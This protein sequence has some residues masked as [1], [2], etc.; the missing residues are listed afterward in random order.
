KAKGNESALSDK[1]K[2]LGIKPPEKIVEKAAEGDDTVG[3]RAKELAVGM[4]ENVKKAGK[5]L[6]G[7]AEDVSE[8]TSGLTEKGVAD[9]VYEQTKGNAKGWYETYKENKKADQTI[10]EAKKDMMDSLI[11]RGATPDG[12]QKAADAMYDGGDASK[13]KKLDELLNLKN[14][15]PDLKHEEAQTDTAA[16]GDKDPGK[17]GKSGGLLDQY[18]SAKATKSKDKDDA[19][20]EGMQQNQNMQTATTSGDKAARDAKATLD[21]AGAEANS[22]RDKSAGDKAKADNEN[23]LGNKL[24]DALETSAKKGGEAFGGAVGT[25]AA[26]NVNKD[27]FSD[28]KKSSD[29][30]NTPGKNVAGDTKPPASSKPP[31]SQTSGGSSDNKDSEPEQKPPTSKGDNKSGTTSK[32]PSSSDPTTK[33]PGSSTGTGT[34]TK[35]PSSPPSPPVVK[36]PPKPEYETVTCPGCKRLLKTPA[37]TGIRC[38][39][40]VTMDCPVCGFTKNYDVGTEPSSCP[41]CAGKKAAEKASA[42]SKG[43]GK[44]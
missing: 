42:A 13:Y 29:S 11:K 43:G 18:T 41:R 21:K 26:D 25:A 9:E 1:F 39:Y 2:Q 24:K 34:Q 20:M 44:K 3:E 27:I 8:I 31:T 15:K 32:P 30:K 16:G 23:S 37:G 10:D 19:A 4:G 17:G 6:K 7:T 14:K 28:N 38:P 33:S 12:A 36:K 22:T 35:P 5:F 40:C